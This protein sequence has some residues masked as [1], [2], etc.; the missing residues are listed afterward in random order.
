MTPSSP[1][2]TMRITE[3]KSWRGIE[4][5]LK[6][7]TSRVARN[8]ITA[9]RLALHNAQDLATATEQINTITC[10]RV[11]AVDLYNESGWDEA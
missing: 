3:H 1:L 10:G 11:R 7:Y 5:F 8:A 2:P 9:Q 6:L 4:L